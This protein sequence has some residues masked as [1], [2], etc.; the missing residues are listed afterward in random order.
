VSGEMDRLRVGRK[1][2]QQIKDRQ[3]AD[4]QADSENDRQTEK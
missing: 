2:Y 1:K 4:T 3:C